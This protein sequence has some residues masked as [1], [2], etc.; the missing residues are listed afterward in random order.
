LQAAQLALDAGQTGTQVFF[1]FGVDDS[2]HASLLGP[3]A[4]V[5]AL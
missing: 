4:M 1:L 2:A 5:R 3:F